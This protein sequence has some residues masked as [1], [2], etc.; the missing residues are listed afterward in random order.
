MI[1][2]KHMCTA[3]SYVTKDHYFGRNLDMEFSY[4]ETVT[5]TPR[6]YPFFFAE[7]TEMRRHYAMIGVAYVVGGYPLYY[8]AV[9]EKGLCMAALSFPHEAVYH[10][11]KEDVQN[12][13]PFELIPYVLGTCATAEEA[14]KLLEGINIWNRPFSEELPL[15]ALHWIISDKTAS[16]TVES[17]REGL[18][19]YEN[20]I[21]VLTNSPSFDFQMKHLNLYMGLSAEPRET[22]FL[23]DVYAFSNGMGALGLPGD[24]SSTSRFVRA[25]F[26]KCHSVSENSEESGV[27]QFFHILGSVEQ[28]R[29]CVHLGENK[30]EITVYSSCCNAD[31]GIYY[32]TTYENR[33]IIGVDM[34]KEHLDER[35]L[36]SYPLI[37]NGGLRLI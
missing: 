21:G 10:K 34:R 35:A 19:L 3:I 33:E 13:A 24:L 16:L 29:G 20:P 8:D 27:H 4:D 7:G 18:R 6:N 14:Q 9:N 25:A 17:V 32:Y 26:T 1:W 11:K 23:R 28:T 22:G 36:I 5:I 37:K 15:T 31:K 30:Y 12:V 2:R